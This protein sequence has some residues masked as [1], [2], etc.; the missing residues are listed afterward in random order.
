MIS[1]IFTALDWGRRE[2]HDARGLFR[3]QRFGRDD[4]GSICDFIE[5]LP[6]AESRASLS[7]I[8]LSGRRLRYLPLI[9]FLSHGYDAAIICRRLLSLPRH[10]KH[11]ID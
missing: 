1:I 11:R 9:D 3:A 5:A 10:F 6:H 8:S 2:I 7:P 4:G